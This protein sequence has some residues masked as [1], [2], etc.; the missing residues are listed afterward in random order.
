MHRRNFMQALGIGGVLSLNFASIALAADGAGDG[1]VAAI[2]ENID[3]RRSVRTYTDEPVTEEQIEKMLRAA[4]AA[5]NAANE[6]PW[7]FVVVTDKSILGQMKSVN[8]YAAYAGHAPLAILVCLNTTKDKTDGMSILDI[9]MASEN[10]MLAAHALGLGSVFTGIY[11][12]KD[13]MEK[14]SQLFKLP[15]EISPIGLIIIGHP[16]TTARKSAEA[17]YN[18]AVIHKNT[19]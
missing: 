6:Q 12:L 9:G 14:A 1:N 7:E 10:L 19:W 8:Q 13:R 4:M 16:K 3:T 11:P 2:L 5:P 17:R 18:T 15:P